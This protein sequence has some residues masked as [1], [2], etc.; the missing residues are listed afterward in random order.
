MTTALIG[1]DRTALNRPAL[2]ARG[3]TKRFGA[4]L[5]L[6]EIDFEIAPGE[7]RGLCGENGAGKSTFIKLLTG[8]Y[9]ADAGEIEV[10]G[11]LRAMSSPRDAQ[12]CG[13]AL[14]AQELSLCPD[15]S[16]EDNIWLGT[17]GV[18]LLHRRR[19]LESRAR[20][21][22][23]QLGMQGIDL[24]APL[25]SLSLGEQQIVEIAR[26]LTRRANVLLLDEPTATLSD[27]EID[28]MMHALRA[29]KQQGCSIIYITHRMGEVFDLCDTLSVFRNGR[30]VATRPTASVARQELV[31][32]MLGRR[33][34]AMFPATAI[35]AQGNRLVI[36]SL[37]I[38]GRVLDFDLRVP[39]GAIVCLAGQIGSGAEDIVRALGGLEHRASGQVE[40]DGR[41]LR[42]GS[43]TSAQRC[44]IQYVSGDRAAE[45]VFTDL[46]V[47]ANL[48]ATRLRKH[49]LWGVLGR[50]SIRDKARQLA[51]R[52]SVDERRMHARASDLSGGNQQKL[53]FG[54]CMDQDRPGVIVMY[55]P[56]RGIDVGARAELYRV[57][58]D[59]CREGHAIVIASTDLEEVL[60]LG[61]LVVTLY[62]GRSVATYTRDQASMARIVADITHPEPGGAS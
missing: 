34:D 10:A 40:I 59:F 6:E 15:L 11:Q 14:V 29:L 54:R 61:D 1:S 25:G 41:K 60:G 58:R 3:L 57:M 13:I 51:R 26:L 42:L 52:V 49:T 36:K 47:E 30:H 46:T 53:A 32:M 33:H 28:K 39:S 20:E 55:E 48:T 37:A 45:G 24:A 12:A 35:P 2:A 27:R 21:A 50:R 44:G 43:T 8:V 5:A 18:P 19:E 23:D 17:L 22:L 56:T 31:E 16:V 4:V 7:I 38:P 62:R 9:R